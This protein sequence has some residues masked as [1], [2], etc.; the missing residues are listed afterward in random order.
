[1]AFDPPDITDEAVLRVCRILRLPETAFSGPNG[2]DPRLA[3]LKSLAARDIEACPGSGKTTLL[4]A[5]LAI[6]A[7]LWTAPRNGL[8]VLSHTNVARREIEQRLGNTAEGQRLLSYPH[9]IGTIHG[10]VNEFLAIP[11]LRSNG[12][13][14]EMI[15]D[16]VALRRRWRK[17][18]HATRRGLENNRYDEGILRIQDAAFGV[19]DMRWGRG[20][21]GRDTPTY[22]AL[23]AACRQSAEEGYFCHNEMFVW[24]HDLI[25]K[26]P[27]VTAFLRARFPFLFIDEIQDN[28]EQQSRLLHRVFAEGDDSVLRQRY[29][30]ANQAIYQNI[31]QSDGAATDPFPAADIRADIPNSF[32]FGQEIADFADPLALAPQGLR[33]NRRVNAEGESDT[34]GK[35]A[36]FLFDDDSMARVLETYAAYLVEVFSERERQDGMFT[37]VG[38]VHRP[39]GDNNLPRNVGHYWPAYDPVISRSD[40]QPQ[41]FIQYVTAGRRLAEMTGETHALVEKIA[42][43]VI[44]LARLMAPGFS[45]GTRKRKHRY[46]LELM[47]DKP[48]AKSAY[49]EL[50]RVMAVERQALTEAAWTADWRPQADHIAHEITGVGAN[51]QAV[52]DFLAWGDA[53]GGGAGQGQESRSD[54]IFR[55]PPDEPAVAVRV[56]SIHA[57]KGETHTATLVLETFYYAHHLKT[58]KPWLLGDRRGGGGA[59]SALQSRLKLHYVAMTRPARLL[60]L[61][62]RED[63]LEPGETARLMRR[64]WR[65]ARIGPA[66]PEWLEAQ[67]EPEQ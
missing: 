54:N 18:S 6:L 48:A 23:V 14:I 49:L 25:D 7:G 24:A 38:A 40:P 43:A 44:R 17:L 15:D 8:C 60:C 37:A 31:S 59:N 32:R 9:F 50:V 45:P 56:G 1:M 41:T 35:H 5:K 46:V 21:L 67:E 47:E 27:E 61:A 55:Y 19:G 62:L 10:F 64:G 12:Y 39:G 22:R 20:A 65:V 11:W 53:A 2:Q 66:D 30:D 51:E 3:V 63:S 57:V 29:G 26:A 34:A 36:I 52:A 28:S 13:P 4:V 33:G 58:L 16:D 42:E